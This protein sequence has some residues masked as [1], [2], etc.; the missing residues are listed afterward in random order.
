[1][2]SASTRPSR[3]STLCDKAHFALGHLHLPGLTPI[4]DH[5]GHLTQ[6]RLLVGNTTHDVTVEQL[7]ERHLDQMEVGSQVERQL[8]PKRPELRRIIRKAEEDLRESISLMDQTEENLS[9]LLG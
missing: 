5:V 1:M 8:Y 6:W 3:H 7:F 4:I 9:L 2:R